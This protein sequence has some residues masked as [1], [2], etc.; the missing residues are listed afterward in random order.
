MASQIKVNE[1][2]KQSGSS[3]TIGESGTTISIPSG[4]TIANSGTA[5]G[6]VD[7]EVS[8]KITQNS[9]QSISNATTT[10]VTFDSTTNGF[11]QG[12]N[13][14]S[15]KFTAP[16]AGRYFFYSQVL[17]EYGNATSEY[18]NL[19]FKIN[20][21]DRQAA[22]RQVVGGA[23]SLGSNLQLSSIINLSANDTVETQIYHTQGNTQA[24]DSS[25]DF[26]FF[27]GFKL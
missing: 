2:I 9:N 6:F 5:T 12:D 25:E 18:G 10:T 3:I 27:M 15:N 21:S 23:V 13:F 20:G 14:A 17:I 8:F 11:D 19:T 7:S 4:A 16:S 1:I 24:I 26:T 22:V